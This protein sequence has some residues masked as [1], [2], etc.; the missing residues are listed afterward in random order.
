[1]VRNKTDTN[2]ELFKEGYDVAMYKIPVEADSAIESALPQNEWSDCSMFYINDS[3]ISQF[4]EWCHR[5]R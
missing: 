1:M 2:S 3:L 5:K 4:I